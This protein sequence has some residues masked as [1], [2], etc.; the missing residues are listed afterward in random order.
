VLQGRK[1]D[2]CQPDLRPRK[3]RHH[4]KGEE[5]PAKDLIANRFVEK[6]SRGKTYGPPLTLIENALGFEEQSLSEPL[7]ADDDEFVIAVRAQK[8]F[9]FR[10]AV[11]QGLIKVLGHLNVVRIYGPRTHVVF[12]VPTTRLAEALAEEQ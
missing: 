2:R 4:K 11:E 9:D 5:F 12:P 8:A 6:R 3:G 7:R 1:T 10:G